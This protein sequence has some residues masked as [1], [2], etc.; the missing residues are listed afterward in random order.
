MKVSKA[1]KAVLAFL[2]VLCAVSLIFIGFS[3]IKKDKIN[4]YAAPNVS[5]N[6]GVT[7]GNFATGIWMDSSPGVAVDK[8]SASKKIRLQHQQIRGITG[9]ALK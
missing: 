2:I 9:L 1:R 8:V 7:N 5:L 3:L 6:P 4:A